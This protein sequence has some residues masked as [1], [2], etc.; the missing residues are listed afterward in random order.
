MK[1]LLCLIFILYWAI[2]LNAQ[3]AWT[4]KKGE[5]YTQIGAS[6]IGYGTL[7]NGNNDLLPIWRN[8]NDFSV[9]LYGDYGI[10]DKWMVNVNLPIKILTS[11]KTLNDSSYLSEAPLNAGNMV[12]LGNTQVGVSY[13]IL[14]NKSFVMAAHMR[15]NMYPLA[16]RQNTGFQTG[17]QAFG[18]MPSIAMG[19]G[20]Q[21]FFASTEFGV[22]YRTHGYSLQFSS[23]TQIGTVIKKK[24]YIILGLDLLFSVPITTL[25]DGDAR[26]TGLYL[27][28]MQYQAPSIKLGW[29]ITPELRVWLAS[30]GLG[31]AGGRELGGGPSFSFSIFYQKKNSE[32]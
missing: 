17:Y 29:A 10:T 24:F 28:R 14:Q 5:F 13:G 30:G 16:P 22:N 4:K 12:G 2:N 32:E 23:L 3:Q 8:V 11:S 1:K 27:D 15:F 18:L 26:H 20:H 21:Y 9:Q 19:Y 7:L 25:R 31:L 6:W